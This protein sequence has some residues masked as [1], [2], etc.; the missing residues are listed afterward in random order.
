MK[1]YNSEYICHRKYEERSNPGVQGASD[2]NK[3][4]DIKNDIID[5]ANDIR[6]ILEE[7]KQIRENL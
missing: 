7:M 4:V 2:Y 3:L 6:M 5:L 1:S